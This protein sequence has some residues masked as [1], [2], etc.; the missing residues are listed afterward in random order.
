LRERRL[1]VAATAA[2]V[3]LGVGGV[4]YATIPSGGAFTACAQN[5]TGALR[6]IDPST[7]HCLP[8]EQQVTWNKTGVTGTTGVTGDTGAPGPSEAWQVFSESPITLPA[9]SYVVTGGVRFHTASATC[10]VL[11]TVSGLGNVG[12]FV[13]DSGADGAESTMPIFSAFTVTA[14]TQFF[15]SCD[16]FE[17]MDVEVIR[18]GTLHLGS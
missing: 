3:A 7:T 18:V 8:S 4:A 11:H 9:G 6:L 1:I 15:L 16:N 17:A 13:D 5:T 12:P 2:I 14:P 10:S